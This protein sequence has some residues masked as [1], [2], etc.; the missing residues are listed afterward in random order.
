M[1]ISKIFEL[2]SKTYLPYDLVKSLNKLFDTDG[3]INKSSFIFTS[4]LLIINFFNI[5]NSVI[6][7]I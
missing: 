7:L 6:L 1:I 3:L 2:Y 5:V 4:Y